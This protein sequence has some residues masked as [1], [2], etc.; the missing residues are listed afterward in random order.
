MKKRWALPLAVA[1]ALFAWDNA[2][3]YDPGNPGRYQ[4]AP[5][6]L[7][8]LLLLRPFGIAMTAVGTG[9]FVATMPFSGIANIAPPHDAFEKTANALVVAPAAFT[10]MRPLGEFSYQPC[11]VYPARPEGCAPAN[12]RR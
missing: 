8:D 5:A 9:F 3:A 2:A 12:V 10:F 4:G 7:A 6:V 1:G 11:G